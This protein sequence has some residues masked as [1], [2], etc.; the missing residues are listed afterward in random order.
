[1]QELEKILSESLKLADANK[2]SGKEITPFLLAQM[3]EKSAGK[4]LAANI[5][6]LENNA[7]VAA[8]VAC[9]LKK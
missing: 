2:I 1:A 9:A 7:R 4:T 6:L 5:A 8:Q 3:S